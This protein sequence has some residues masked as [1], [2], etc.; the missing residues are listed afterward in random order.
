MTFFISLKEFFSNSMI[1]L[2][3]L[4]FVQHNLSNSEVESNPQHHAPSSTAAVDQAATASSSRNNL[5]QR[6]DRGQ[7]SIRHQKSPEDVAVTESQV[8]LLCFGPMNSQ[9]C[10][11]LRELLLWIKIP[12]LVFP[13]LF[14]TFENPSQVHLQHALKVLLVCN[15]WWKIIRYF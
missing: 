6:L 13:D 3:C 4:K 15:F 7:H 12:W 11:D 14:A 8:R 5:H 10:I 1:I 9:S 2:T